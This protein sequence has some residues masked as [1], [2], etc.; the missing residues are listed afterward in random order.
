MYISKQ[1]TEINDT[2]FN[3]TFNLLAYPHFPIVLVIYHVYSYNI[4][5]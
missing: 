4:L 5:L 1:T 2:M 3:Y